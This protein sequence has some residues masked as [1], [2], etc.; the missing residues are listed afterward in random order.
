MS[1]VHISI[2]IPTFN[3]SYILKKIFENLKK[4]VNFNLS[5]EVLVC[6]SSSV[7]NTRQLCNLYSNNFKY[8][9]HYLNSKINNLSAKRNLGIKSASSNKLI[10][11]DDDCIPEV[12]FL[13]KYFNYLK[14]EKKIFCGIVKYPKEWLLKS[15]YLNYRQS[16]HF[17]KIDSKQLKP[18]NIVVMNMGIFIKNEDKKNLYF[19]ER[20]TGYGFEDYEFAKRMIKNNFKIYKINANI[21]HY[22]IKSNFSSYIKKMYSLSKYGVPNLK[23][24][25]IKYFEDT[26]YHQIEKKFFIKLLKNLKFLKSIFNMII[27]LLILLDKYGLLYSKLFYRLAILLSYLNGKY[28]RDL[29]IIK[30]KKNWYE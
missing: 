25:N 11:I 14:D 5:F 2:I 15:N 7:D 8:K 9:L 28:D 29:R 23:R 6:D 26:K 18:N 3:R 24:I 12:N 19:D 1:K 17:E 13:S 30:N 16:T 22:E 4:Q 20:F 21:I 10:F 27:H